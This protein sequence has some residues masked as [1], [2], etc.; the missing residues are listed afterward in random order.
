VPEIHKRER[1]D[2][3]EALIRAALEEEQARKKAKKGGDAAGV[4]LCVSGWG[5][6][7]RGRSRWVGWLR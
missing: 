2:D 5:G 4:C 3:T 6:Q 1:D 7:E